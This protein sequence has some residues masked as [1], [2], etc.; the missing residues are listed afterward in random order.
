MLCTVCCWW[1]TMVTSTV[2][3]WR[4]EEATSVVGLIHAG[5]E[6]IACMVKLCQE[7]ARRMA[8]RI[9]L[10]RTD[11]I[12]S[13]IPLLVGCYH[14]KA[15]QL[16]AR[17]A[18]WLCRICSPRQPV[19]HAYCPSCHL[20]SLT[21]TDQTCVCRMPLMPAGM[22]M[23]T[24]LDRQLCFFFAT[25][26]PQVLA[27]FKT[28]RHESIG[29]KLNLQLVFQNSLPWR[30]MTPH[31]TIHAFSMCCIAQE[32]ACVEDEES[33]GLCSTKQ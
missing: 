22:N 7:A 19:L 20:A 4:K 24:Q 12:I 3:A 26:A 15:T 5:A 18:C 25:P 21:A 2:S 17:Q 8:Q 28:R 11:I 27:A 10:F 29:T 14:T 32:S 33:Q 9:L 23:R 31:G 13:D 1:V 16:E 30:D 6:A